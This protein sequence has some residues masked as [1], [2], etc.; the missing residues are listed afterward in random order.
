MYA[1]DQYVR[2]SR[3]TT[4][5][6]L[7]TSI[8]FLTMTAALAACGSDDSS[9]PGAGTGSVQVFVVP[10]ETISEGLDPGSDLENV[11]D[12]WTIRYSRYLVAVGNFRASRS[13]TGDSFG[14]PTV[15]ILD[16]K[17]APTQG[18]LVHEFSEIAAARWD[19]FGYD[20]P[21]AK[22]G[23][24]PLSPT[25]EADANFMITNGYSVYYEGTAE[26]EGETYSFKWGFAAGTSFD[27]CATDDGVAGF[28]VPTSGTVQI[29]PTLHGDHQYFSNVTQGVELTDRLAEWI[30]TCDADNNKETTLDEIKACSASDALPQPPY[31]LSDVVDRDGDKKLTVY[32][33]VNSQMRTFGDFQG[34]GECPTRAAL[35]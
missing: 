3:K 30:K 21:N 34:D 8:C 4:M 9:N 14:D 13:A 16:L 1:L 10:E 35:K 26:K 5:K 6:T 25:T 7:L 12:G 23:A 15:Y 29:K 11:K 27:D 19:K 17:A 33:Y 22:S 32:D 2:R 24:K 31:D 28:A 18:Y 20:V